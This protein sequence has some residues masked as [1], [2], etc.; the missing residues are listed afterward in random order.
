MESLVTSV[1]K[2]KKT[3][4]TIAEIQTECGGEESA[5]RRAITALRKKG[6]VA[7]EKG[8]N[9]TKYSLIK[10]V[11]APSWYYALHAI[12]NGVTSVDSM[13]YLL[14]RNEHWCKKAVEYLFGKN[15]IRE[16]DYGWF[17][18]TPTGEKVLDTPFSVDHTMMARACQGGDRGM[19]TAACIFDA[20]IKRRRSIA[21]AKTKS[22]GRSKQKKE[23]RAAHNRIRP[24]HELRRLMGCKKLSE[25][26]RLLGFSDSYMSGLVAGKGSF[27]NVLFRACLHLDMSPKELMG[28]IGM[29]PD[30]CFF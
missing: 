28:K 16:D 5:I 15:Y 29:D 2:K 23:R 22:A 25:L 14:A 11:A 7:G 6:T 20:A 21:G 10:V 17:V 1:L 26:D 12:K 19:R 30:T 27:Q 24:V 8:R 13:R 9:G 3:A 18:L 4:L